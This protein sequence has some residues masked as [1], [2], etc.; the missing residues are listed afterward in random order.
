MAVGVK[1][2]WTEAEEKFLKENY[3]KMTNAELAKALGLKLTL[4]RTKLYSMGLKRME[5]E[6]WTNE[7]VEF[8]KKKYRYIGDVELTEIFESKWKK[9]KGWTK[10]HIEK[11]R[12]YLKLKRTKSEIQ[13]IFRRNVEAGRFQICVQ[14]M[15][16]V[17]GISE[18]G[19]IRIWKSQYGS[20][21]KVIKTKD[22]FVHYKRWLWEK[23]HGP[24][25]EG[26]LVATKDMDPLNITPENLELITREQHG[27]RVHIRKLPKELR[28]TAL[29]VKKIEKQLINK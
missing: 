2:I 20:D 1:H 19:T 27:A 25:P 14:K 22:G 24:V 8:L 23:L 13:D 9:D 29:L 21:F 15:W 10:K 16:K 3:E 5:M 17:K 7:Q 26:Y 12:R 18:P 28:R 11:K 4:T 6:Y